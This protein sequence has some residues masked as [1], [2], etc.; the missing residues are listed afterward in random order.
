MLSTKDAVV[1]NIT[2]SENRIVVT[3]IL[4]L[5]GDADF[6]DP[7]APAEI[8]REKSGSRFKFELHRF[9]SSNGK[10]YIFES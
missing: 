3:L 7:M 1:Q 9:I 4:N 2:E 5:E 8:W 10:I 6:S